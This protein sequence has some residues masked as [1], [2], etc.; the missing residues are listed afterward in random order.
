MKA[1]Q[2]FFP[3]LREI[4]VEAEVASHQLLLRAGYICKTGTGVYTYL[5]LGLRVIHKISQIVRVE[6]N[7][8]E[9]QEIMMPII[10]PRALWE[11]TGRWNV[12]GEEMFKL[13]DRHGRYFALGPTHEEL[14]TSL[15]HD[16]IHSYR[17][18]PLRLYQ[19]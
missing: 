10:Q 14:I 7:A 12:Y 8:A 2:L 15:I 3:T 13:K 6:M 16:E 4:P 18:L 9:G 11:T 17:N 1:S 5:P 19:I